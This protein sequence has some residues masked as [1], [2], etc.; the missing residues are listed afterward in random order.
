VK[1][2]EA[3]SGPVLLGDTIDIIERTR[4]AFFF[5]KSK[6]HRCDPDNDPDDG[7][8]ALTKFHALLRTPKPRAEIWP[9]GSGHPG[10]VAGKFRYQAADGCIIITNNQRA[11]LLDVAGMRKLRPRSMSASGRTGRKGIESDFRFW[12]VTGATAARD[13]G[14]FL[15][16]TRRGLARM[17]IDI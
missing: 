16:S 7:D 2:Y 13:D 6:N 8:D 9:N 5:P 1:I 4:F 17:P 10:E 12:P 3:C 11:R 15:G 14:R